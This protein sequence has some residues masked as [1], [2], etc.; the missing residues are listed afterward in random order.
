M[1][2]FSKY[3]SAQELEA[4]GAD[5]IKK[6]LQ[7]RGLLCG[8]TLSERAARLYLLKDTP[9]EVLDK[10]LFAEDKKKMK[11]A[12]RRKNKNNNKQ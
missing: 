10:K 5:E 2:D 1:L 4:L 9:L 6:E 11:N 7:S 12:K 8:G 3:N